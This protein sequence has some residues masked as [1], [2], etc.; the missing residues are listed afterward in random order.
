MS[1]LLSLIRLLC[2]PL[3]LTIHDGIGELKWNADAHLLFSSDLDEWFIEA[4]AI[5]PMS[6]EIDKEKEFFRLTTEFT[7]IP[8]GMVLRTR[9][10]SDTYREIEYHVD[11]GELFF[12]GEQYHG[13]DYY[14]G[15]DDFWWCTLNSAN[16]GS[17][18]LEFP[19][20]SQRWCRSDERDCTRQRMDHIR[21]RQL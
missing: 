11:T 15:S 17:G 6:W 19:D 7:E 21:V 2:L 10:A 3:E 4:E 12:R 16:R 9:F 1:C 5:S 8:R 14:G 18:L 13:L 20:G